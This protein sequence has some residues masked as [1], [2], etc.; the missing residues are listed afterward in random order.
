M[1]LKRNS[2]QLKESLTIRQFKLRESLTTMILKRNRIHFRE[3]LITLILKRNSR[4]LSK[5]LTI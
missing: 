4:Q 3:S 5:S 2:R 1:I